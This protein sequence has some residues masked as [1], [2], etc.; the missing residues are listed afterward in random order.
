MNVIKRD[1]S[2]A[3]FDYQKIL[4]AIKGANNDCGP[5]DQIPEGEATAITYRVV[6]KCNKFGRALNV[7]EIQ[8]LVEK[9]IA[10][11]GFLEAS[12]QYTIYRY[13]QALK[14]QKNTT[15]DAVLALVDGSNEEMK[16]ENSNKNPLTIATQ[17][18]YM[19]GMVSR[20]LCRRYLY[21]KDVVAAHDKGAI[22]IHK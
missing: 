18:D 16:Q 1:G 14:R 3:V 2:E 22:H 8:D 7:E 5:K 12:K 11:A 13:E 15:D 19:A 17:R 6:D 20:D 21:P 4:A 9:E 10:L